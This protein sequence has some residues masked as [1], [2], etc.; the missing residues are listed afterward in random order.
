MTERIGAITGELRG[1]ARKATGELAD[2]A[3]DEAIEGALLLLRDRVAR[4]QV[5]I[6]RGPGEA[7][8][9]RAERIRLE[10]V[11]V[12]LLGNALDALIDQPD[13]EIVIGVTASDR[14]VEVDIADNGPAL[15]AAVRTS[16]E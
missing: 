11:L 8:L 15:S 14:R 16:R 7:C 2:V 3:L 5:A 4:Q 13:P 6:R 1:F 10:Q 9:V 12:N